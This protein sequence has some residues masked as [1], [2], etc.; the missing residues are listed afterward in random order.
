MDDK[1][2]TAGSSFIY[3][4]WRGKSFIIDERFA[5][6][7]REHLIEEGESPEEVANLT[8]ERIMEDL[9]LYESEE[10]YF[11]LEEMWEKPEAKTNR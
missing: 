5:K 11:Q 2:D 8:P 7:F 1:A 6:D 10:R 4:N 9:P 3:T